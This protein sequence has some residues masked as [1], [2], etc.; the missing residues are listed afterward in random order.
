MTAVLANALQSA[1]D[2]CRHF[3]HFGADFVMEFDVLIV[4]SIFDR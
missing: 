4:E 3:V 1:E 2:L